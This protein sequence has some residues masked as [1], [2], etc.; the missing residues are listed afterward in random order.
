MTKQ[1]SSEKCL[2]GSLAGFS[3]FRLSTLTF[4]LTA[5]LLAGSAVAGL[6]QAQ[7]DAAK[8]A[9]TVAPAKPA[10]EPAQKIVGGYMVHQSLEVGG[11]ITTVTG[12][13]A[14]W[15]T[16]VNQ[17]SGG[18]I[19]EQS[20][21]MHSVN[22]S[23]TPFFDTLTTYSTGYGGDPLNVTRLRISKGRWYD[24]NGSFRRDRNYFDYNL[25]D[26]S[27]LGPGAL[28]AEPDSLHLFNTV[29]RNTD[30]TLTLLPLSFISFRAGFNHGTHEGPSYTSVHEGADAQL[31]QWFR[32]GS[33]TYTG[34]IDVKLAKRTTLSYDQFFVLYKGDS[35]F[36]LT[37]ANY[38][39]S[40]GQPV[41]LGVDT[42]S[43]ATCGTGANKTPEVVNNIANPYCNGFLTMSQTAPTRTQFP[44][45]QLR[46]NTHYWNRVYMNAR[47]LYSGATGSVNN[48]N[49]TFNGLTTR[50]GERAEIDTG[51]FANGQMAQTKRVDVNAD[52]GIVAELNK[53]FSITDAF[54][55]WDFRV[56]GTN[57]VNSAVYTD[58]SK[59]P[60][61]L[62]PLSSITPT[63]T[64]TITSNF[65]TQR[66][67]SNTLMAIATITPEVKV[68]GGWR[69]QTR[70][71]TDSGQDDLTWN[72]NGALLGIVIQPSRMVRVNVDYDSMSS[73]S[74]NAITPSNT[75]TR[76]APD[77]ANH[78]RARASIKPA[79]W[80]NLAITGSDYSAKN[81]DPLVNHT[82]HNHD[83]SFAATIIAGEGFSLDFNFAHDSVF[84][85]TDTCYSFTPTATEPLPPGAVNAGTCVLTTTN[86]GGSPSLYLGNGFYN[87]P[88][89]F[90]SGAVNY[91]PSKYLH[92][93]AGARV[94]DSNGQAEMLN[95]L[96]V[97][98]A[99]Q[100]KYV[101]PYADMQINIASQWAWHGNWTHDGYAEGGPTGYLPSRNAHGDIVT[102]GV[103]YAF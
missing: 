1:T 48:F 10:A 77:K 75:Y 98:G 25:L 59:T 69:V 100:S 6:A 57:N 73:K 52:Y 9:P 64:N 18:R 46:F 11:R 33:D 27:L 49:E 54:D 34:G 63:T 44:S 86:P 26:Q 83:L 56:P 95:A 35:T 40:N 72:I 99:I 102:L 68:S 30:T 3:V 89:N 62:D 31:F 101:T 41:S 65:L 67:E 14:M 29:R 38:M 79:K 60:S 66:I 84:S 20:L 12:S 88:T 28:V 37:G 4:A 87:V 16:L 90:F 19:L 80:I 43:S 51:G 82:E 94:N 53:Y 50:T 85:V 36:Q 2:V 96:M 78:L 91:S 21:E 81:D 5:I 103:K 71:I 8:P 7:P 55:Y 22:N 23:K 17:G 97:P 93:N 74:S 13:D 24:F 45:E 47:V 15:D 70:N 39:L 76:E 32:N 58:P 61:M 42:L 92:F